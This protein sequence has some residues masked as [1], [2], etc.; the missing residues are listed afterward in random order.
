MQRTLT[1]YRRKLND[2]FFGEPVV[3][4]SDELW[5]YGVQASGLAVALGVWVVI[6]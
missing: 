5:F 3:H 2:Y 4:I 6:L 1:H